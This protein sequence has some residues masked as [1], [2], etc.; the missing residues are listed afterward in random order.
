MTTTTPGITEE[1][2][3]LKTFSDL[4]KL[5]RVTAW[6]K[7][8]L[9]TARASRM[10][11]RS[12]N[13]NRCFTPLTV[14][15][16]DEAEKLWIRQVQA[17]N[18]KGELACVTSKT[19]LNK[20]SPLTS[21]NPFLDRGVLRVCGRLKHSLLSFEEKHPAI[22]LSDSTLTL[23]IIQACHRKTLHGGAQLTLSLVRHKFWIPRNRSLVKS[24]IHR[25]ITCV[26]WRAA[27]SQQLIVDL[28]SPRVTPV[29]PFNS[30]GVD[31]AGPVM[32]RTAPGRGH[33]ST[34]AFFVVFVCL[35][36]KAVHL[37]VASSYSAEAFLAVFRRFVSRRGLCAEIYSGT[38]FVGADAELRRMFVTS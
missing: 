38:N 28:P 32:L 24:S 6:C 13:E 33:K 15:E 4:H 37:N 29:R 2:P 31:Y 34:K 20:K 1:H 22:L 19:P 11:K 18:Y 14:T 10:R 17:V 21:L 5:L 35:V 3:L 30:T 27:T 36:T 16:L 25:C 26:R 7:R 12:R 23:L 8:W 9:L